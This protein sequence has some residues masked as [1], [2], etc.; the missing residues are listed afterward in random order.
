MI[1]KWDKNEYGSWRGFIIFLDDID[2][3]KEEEDKVGFFE[4]I[5][6]YFF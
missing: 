6:S 4:Y 1:T 2:I 5:Y 3:D